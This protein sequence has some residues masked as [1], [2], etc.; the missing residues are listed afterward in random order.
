MLY[1]AYR[2]RYPP[3]RWCSKCGPV[4]KWHQHYPLGKDDPQHEDRT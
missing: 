3:I 1:A 4:N 2:R